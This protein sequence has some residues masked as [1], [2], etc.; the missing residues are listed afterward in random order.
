MSRGQGVLDCVLD[1]G[2]VI[3]CSGAA[4]SL[5]V[6]QSHDGWWRRDRWLHSALAFGGAE[7]G[8]GGVPEWRGECW[9]ARSG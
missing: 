9:G 5:P 7:V 4:L 8:G 3:V 1:P 6:A 2:E